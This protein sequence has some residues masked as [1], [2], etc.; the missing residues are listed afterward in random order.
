MLFVRF[1]EKITFL[2]LDINFNSNL[3][4]QLFQF[5]LD[6][7]YKTWFYHNWKGSWQGLET[8]KIEY[9]TS[10]TILAGLK[11]RYLWPASK[12]PPC[13]GKEYR[14]L[15]RASRHIGRRTPQPESFCLAL[16]TEL[17]KS[18]IIA[19]DIELSKSTSSSHYE[20]FSSQPILEIFLSVSVPHRKKEIFLS[21]TILDRMKNILLSVD[22]WNILIDI[23]PS[24][25][26]IFLSRSI[27]DQSTTQVY[28]LKSRAWSTPRWWTCA[29]ASWRFRPRRCCLSST[30][31]R[32]LTCTRCSTCRKC[33]TCTFVQD[34]QAAQ[35]QSQQE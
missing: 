30:S 12:Y 20:I 24:L 28:I 16:S 7:W 25:K 18:V 34:V 13:C 8:K 23:G 6:V 27:L 26:E 9:L 33:P 11:K 15:E 14:T 21:E 3:C 19:F 35:V 17:L 4:E 1:E 32:S 31:A 29:P 2:L 5:N 10:N 22:P